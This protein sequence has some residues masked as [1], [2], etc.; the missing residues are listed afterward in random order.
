MNLVSELFITEQKNLIFKHEHSKL[1]A[2]TYK[3]NTSDWSKD[4]NIYKKREYFRTQN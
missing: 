2:K 3:Y 1:S 4:K